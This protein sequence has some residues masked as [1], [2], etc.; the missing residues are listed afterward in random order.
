VTQYRTHFGLPVLLN[1]PCTSLSRPLP[2]IS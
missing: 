2:P 1:Y